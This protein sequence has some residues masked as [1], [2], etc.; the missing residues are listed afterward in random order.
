MVGVGVSKDW[1]MGGIRFVSGS[2][3]LFSC[4]VGG[5]IKR[6]EVC[7]GCPLRACGILGRAGGSVRAVVEE[8]GEFR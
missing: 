1:V 2:V 8:G 6:R 7:G 3:C 4:S 5:R